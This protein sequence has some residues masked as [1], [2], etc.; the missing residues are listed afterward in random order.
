MLKNL[1]GCLAGSWQIWQ[2]YCNTLMHDCREFIG[3]RSSPDGSNILVAALSSQD[4][5]TDAEF[6]SLKSRDTVPLKQRQLA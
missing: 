2:A 5:L 1:Q 3:A 4:H 6:R